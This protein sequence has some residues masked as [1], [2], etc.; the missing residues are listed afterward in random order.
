MEKIKK[1]EYGDY[2]LLII[3]S[4]NFICDDFIFEMQEKLSKNRPHPFISNRWRKL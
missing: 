1:D 4:G 2:L 3:F